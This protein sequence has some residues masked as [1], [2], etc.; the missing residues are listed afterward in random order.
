MEGG[1]MPIPINAI[2]VGLM[3]PLLLV[4]CGVGSNRDVQYQ[5]SEAFD[6]D[7]SLMSARAELGMATV[8]VCY[9]L[10]SDL[11]W[12]LGRLPGDV[13]IVSGAD[14]VWVTHFE[15]LDLREA[16]N[17]QLARR[18]DRLFIDLP[19]GFELQGA[20][21]VVQRL[22]ASLPSDPDWE[23]IQR[24]L[25]DMQSGIVIEPLQGADGLSFSLIA[26]PSDMTDLQAHN[27]VDGIAEPVEIGPWELPVEFSD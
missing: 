7:M 18:C 8:S 16:T 24:S 21:F 23:Q 12:V 19:E 11:D 17:S 26:R 13:S 4:G 6:P 10:P 1:Q 9:D 15:L 5:S 3:V 25:D 27:V 14:T 22:A 2:L 20:T